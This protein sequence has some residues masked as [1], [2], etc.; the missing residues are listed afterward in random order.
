MS[1]PEKNGFRRRARGRAPDGWIPLLSH[2]VFVVGVLVAAGAGAAPPDQDLDGVLDGADNCARVAN[3]DQA[4]GDALPAGDAC[5]CSDVDVDRD[6]D[7]ADVAALERF[8]AGRATRPGFDSARCGAAGAPGCDAADVATLRR[9]LAGQLPGL[10]QACAAAGL[11]H[12]ADA[13]DD[14]VVNALDGSIVGFCQGADLVARCDCRE[15]DIDVD[16]DVDF[17][18][19]VLVSS[20]F[21]QSGFP[22]GA[23]DPGP[24]LVRFVSPLAGGFTSAAPVLARVRVSEATAAVTI[25]GVPAARLAGGLFEAS[26]ALPQGA[27]ELEA[28]A[29]GASCVFETARVSLR[30]PQLEALELAPAGARLVQAGALQPLEL[31]GRYED[32]SIRDLTADAGTRYEGSNAYIASVNGPVV[33]AVSNGEMAVTASFGG[34]S[35]RS[36]I[37]VEIGVLLEAFAVSPEEETLRGAGATRALR[38]TGRFSD[39]SSRDLTAASTGTLWSSGDPAVATVS[40]DGLVRASASGDVAISARNEA[41]SDAAAIRVV[42]SSGSGFL[43]GEAFDDTLGLPLGAVTATLVEDG[44]GRLVPAPTTLADER[45]RFLLGGAGGD[46]L[47]RVARQGYTRVDRRA[48]IPAGTAATLLDA[49]L[50]PLDPRENPIAAAV[51]GSAR[52]AS[53]R[54]SLEVPPGAL[55]LD[56]ALALTELSSQGLQGRLPLGWSPVAALDVSPDAIAFGQPASARLPSEMRLPPGSAVVAARYD[57]SAARWIALAPATVDATGGAASV[58]LPGTG[59]VALLVPDGA[60]FAPPAPVAGE[61]L[62]GVGE[63]ALPA[64]ALAESEVLPPSAP[65]GIG[66]RAVGELVLRS[67]TPFPSGTAVEGRVTEQFDLFDLSMIVPQPFAQDL[68]VFARPRLAETATAGTR[69][70]ITPS[71]D[72]SLTELAIGMVKIAVVPRAAGVGGEVL[73]ADGGGAGDAAGARLELPAGA[74]A[75]ATIALVRALGAGELD[76]PLPAGLELLAAARVDLSSAS[77]AQPGVVS[78][79][80]P[81]GLP[82][83]AQVLVARR[84]RDPDGVARL[85]LVGLARAAAGRLFSDA[86]LAGATLPGVAREG[87]YLFVRAAA[88]L[89]FVTGV[90]RDAGGAPVAQAL[91]RTSTA[92]FAALT[93]SPE[94][95]YLVAGAVGAPTS[96]SALHIPTRDATSGQATVAAVGELATLDLVLGVVAPAVVSTSPANA[97]LDVLRNAP[98]AVRFSEPIEPSSVSATSVVLATGGAPVPG[99]RVLS[100]DGLE[101]RVLPD[102]GLA[103]ATAYTLALSGGLRDLAGNALAPFAG[104]AFTTIDTSKPPQPAAGVITAELPDDQGFVSVTAT[105]GTAEPLSGITLV[106]PRTRETF[107]A[108][109]QSDGAFRLRIGA[110]I[111]DTLALTFRD[112][113]RR[114]LSLPITQ[115]ENPD[116]R[117]AFGGGGGVVRGPSGRRARVMPRAL[118]GG[119]VFQLR[120]VADPGALPALPA[121]FAYRDRFELAIEGAEFRRLASLQLSETQS[122]FAPLRATGFPFEASGSL[123]VPAN[124]L[125]NGTLDFDAVAE[126]SSGERHRVSLETLVVPSN[127]RTGVVE[128]GFL[129]SFPSLFLRAPEQSLVSQQL[130]VSAVAPPARVDFELPDPG[131]APNVVLLLVRLTDV[132]GQPRLAIVDRFERAQIEAMA[133]LRTTGRELPG[134]TLSGSYAVVESSAPLAAVSGQLTGPAATVALGGTPFVFEADAPNAGFRLPVVAGAPFA[135]A[136]VDPESGVSRGGTSGVAPAQGEQDLGEPLAASAT[137]MAVSLEPGAGALVPIDARVVLRFSEPV[138]AQSVTSGSVLLTDAAGSAVPGGFS[139]AAEGREVRFTPSRRL[140]FGT[141]YRCSV[142]RDVVG[143]SGA[144]LPAA[145]STSFDTFAPQVLVSD[146]LDSVRDVVASGNLALAAGAVALHVLDV[147]EPDAPATLASVPLEGGVSGVALVEG[148]ALTDRNGQPVV[149]TLALALSGGGAVPGRL[150]IFS[151]ANAASPALIGAVQLT[152]PSGQTTP[153]GVPAASGTP[154]AAFVAGADAFVA[155]RGLGVERVRLGQA[156][157][158]DPAL[159]GAGLEGR[160]PAAALESATGVARLGARVLTVGAAGLIVL[161]GSSLVRLGGIGTDGQPE[162]VAALEG[163]AFDKNGDGTLETSERFDVALVANGADGTLQLFDVS[164]PASPVRLSVIRLGHPALSVAVDAEQRLALVGGGADGVSL[165][166][167]DGPASIQP[168]ELDSNQL[169]DRILG[170]VA[171]EGVAAR[172]ALA[173]A[174]G[175]GYVADGARGVSVVQ[176]APPRSTFERVARD[177]LA[178]SGGDEE[179][180]EPLGSAFLSD[181]RILVD[182]FATVPPRTSAS[183][184]LE[185]TPLAGGARVL[186]VAGGSRFDLRNGANSVPVEIRK[187]V[188]STGAAAAFVVRDGGGRALARFDLSLAP[189]ETTALELESLLVAPDPLL[190]GQSGDVGRLSLGGLF[191]DGRVRNLTDAARGTTWIAEE[192]AVA[193]VDGAGVVTAV[194]GGTTRLE[195]ANGTQR[196]SAWVNVDDQPAVVALGVSERLL[197]L[198]RIGAQAQL[199]V[200]GRLSNGIVANVTTG[201]GTSFTTGDPS[202]ATVDPAGLVTATGEGEA[203]ITVAN[204]AASLLARVFVESRPAASV[205][206]I[207][208]DAFPTPVRVDREIVA[209]ARVLGSGALEALPVRFSVELNP[210]ADTTAVTDFEGRAAGL[211]TRFGSRGTFVVTASVVD[212]ATGQTRSAS[213]DLVI[214]AGSGDGEPN[215]SLA[216]AAPLDPERPV[217]G[218]IGAG[219]ASD[220]FRVAAST[221]G[222]LRVR[223]SLPPGTDLSRVMV[224]VRASD[225]S[226]IARVTPDAFESELSAS[227]GAGAAFVSL[228]SSAATLL[229]YA[230]ETS[231]AQGPVVVGG[232]VPG[233]GGPG[234]LVA[235]SGSG[236]SSRLDENVVLFGGIAGELVSATPTAL[237]VR[238]PANGVNGQIEVVVRGRSAA[239]PAFATGVATP[240]PSEYTAPDPALQRRHPSGLLVIAN[241]LLASFLPTIGRARVEALVAPLGGAVVGFLPTFNTYEI[242]FA[243]VASVSALDARRAQLLASPDVLRAFPSAIEEPSQLAGTRPGADLAAAEAAQRTSA[244]RVIQAERAVEAVRAS[245]GFRDAASLRAVTVGVIDSGFDPPADVAGEYRVGTVGTVELVDAFAPLDASGFLPVQPEFQEMLS[246]HGTAVTS[247]IAAINQGSHSSGILSGVFRDGERFFQTIVYRVGDDSINP[248]ATG[249]PILGFPITVVWRALEDVRTRN[250]SGR[251]LD[252]LNLSFGSTYASFGE[253]Y[254]SIRQEYQQR[255]QLVADRTLVSAAA[256]NLGIDARLNLPSAVSQ[257]VPGVIAVGAVAV[258]DRDQT[259]EKIDYRAIFGS[260]RSDRLPAGFPTSMLCDA[261]PNAGSNCGPAV[262]LAAPGEDVLVN[263]AGIRL[264]GQTL[265]LASGTSVAA[266]MVTAVAALLQ[267]IRP[268]PP[269]PFRPDELRDLLLRSAEDISATW[270]PSPMKRLNALAAVRLLV[271]IEELERVYIA[272]QEGPNGRLMPGRIVALDVDPISTAQGLAEEIDLSLATPAGSWLGGRPTMLALS[273]DGSELWALVESAAPALGDGLLVIRTD[274]RERLAFIPLSGATFPAA[275]AVQPAQGA[276]LRLASNRAQ[277]VFSRDGRVLYVATGPEIVIVNAV[278]RKLVRRLAD[279]PSPYRDDIRAGDEARFADALQRLRTRMRVGILVNQDPSA[280]FFVAK[281]LLELVNLALAPDGRTLYVSA[282]TGIGSGNQPGALISLDVDLYRDREPQRVGLQADLSSYFSLGSVE[283]QSDP[284]AD[285]VGVGQ[286][287][288]PE[289][290]AVSPDGKHVYLLNPGVKRF[291]GVPPDEFDAASWTALLG[292]SMLLLV[293]PG[294]GI[295]GLMVGMSAFFTI[296]SNQQTDL[297]RAYR[298]EF[299]SGVTLLAAPGFTGVFSTSP[300]LEREWLFPA[301]VI[302]G[303]NP[304]HAGQSLPQG[305]TFSLG[306]GRLVNHRSVLHEVYARRPKDMAIRPDGKRAIVGFFQTGNFG[307][308]DLETQRLFATNPPSAPAPFPFYADPDRRPASSAFHDLVAVTP[309]LRL[310]SHLWPELGLIVGTRISGPSAGLLFAIP[311]PQEALLFVHDVEYSQSGRFAVATHSGGSTV[312]PV[313]GVV[314]GFVDPQSGLNFEPGARLALSN[315]GYQ[316]LSGGVARLMGPGGAVLHE[317]TANTAATFERGGGAI[318]ILDDRV[319]SQELT[320]NA[321]R[322]VDVGD[323]VVNPIP[324]AHYSTFPLRGAT[325][326]FLDYDTTAAQ[327]NRF[328]KPR[329]VA[330]QPLIFFESPGFGDHVVATTEIQL[331]W[332]DARAR[333]ILVRVFDLDDLVPDPADP[334]SFELVPRELG[335]SRLVPSAAERVTRSTK[336]GLRSLIGAIFRAPPYLQPVVGHHYRIEAQLFTEPAGG[337][338]LATTDF[339]VVLDRKIVSQPPPARSCKAKSVSL[340]LVPSPNNDENEGTPGVLNPDTPRVL[341]PM[342]FGRRATLKYTI[343]PP[344]GRSGLDGPVTLQLADTSL[345]VQLGPNAPQPNSPTGEFRGQF[346]I[347]IQRPLPRPAD[348]RYVGSEFEVLLSYAF[349]GCLAE[350]GGLQST[351]AKIPVLSNE[352]EY[353]KKVIPPIIRSDLEGE[354]CAVSFTGLGSTADAVGAASDALGYNP[355]LCTGRLP[356]GGLQRI[357]TN[358]PALADAESVIQL[359]DGRVVELFES[360]GFLAVQRELGSGAPGTGGN[361]DTWVEKVIR[362]RPAPSGAVKDSHAIELQGSRDQPIACLGAMGAP[363]AEV[364]AVTLKDFRV[365]IVFQR[366]Q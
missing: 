102:G 317:V 244:S 227:L 360:E 211:L 256:G 113:E 74:L 303:W 65:A 235:V 357:C 243:G 237:Q 199:V 153:A 273:P 218:T 99:Q 217:A 178:A 55:A 236:F 141:G 3:L 75:Q 354:G 259:G 83:G 200:S 193:R 205:T 35:D 170:R 143:V 109:T 17:A 315:L 33:T 78:V 253:P 126:D 275:P 361:T 12:D 238:V 337:D 138:D 336:R 7:A 124:F 192:P 228:E 232:A 191:S 43:R 181:D 301:D 288:E 204:G 188:A 276:P 100:P 131:G 340:T 56:A 24:P 338:L 358:R 319:I 269:T 70:P 292:A 94:A 328:H 347:E 279:L 148:A 245:R 98:I 60:P 194:A 210:P 145:L 355:F 274:T 291:S 150:S 198:P 117:T 162:A 101:L 165:V 92:P 190:L 142:S 155:V 28:R 89:G 171:T 2:A 1:E 324:R 125:V 68:L 5:Q 261:L 350:P 264:V 289:A 32:G 80:L 233:A 272:D 157:P 173:L 166:D 251:A 280:A 335:E 203:V 185:E 38:A 308:L 304:S 167:L 271:P 248:G 21:T 29:Q 177:P 111:G 326:T 115:F 365:F 252:A 139:L 182:V 341:K 16:G 278:E 116:G 277:P 201:F 334:G 31:V 11:Q 82:P 168:I 97:A 266:P 64:A 325:T 84:F 222:T 267:S 249:D 96:A 37:T 106:N 134:A 87:D 322:T 108:R 241:R 13:N 27:T 242:E 212:P 34:L 54:V 351:R 161:E 18:D 135:L 180:L 119:A 179:A 50:T 356:F 305:A 169:D 309:S 6:V 110:E 296:N 63:I 257:F 287:D 283:T 231:F 105:V 30:I 120:D 137:T 270:T 160:Y 300:G 333:S 76:A 366:L 282:R 263:A 72:F 133:A 189:H 79:P 66:A 127:P 221:D 88:P 187:D 311:S 258:E 307:I 77:L 140:R 215:D 223:L 262:T 59:Q 183:L 349:N 103:S 58:S 290:V 159:P 19:L 224:V 184:Q 136:F 176:L 260:P 339:Q 4:N 118:V 151:L 330:I 362:D 342:L 294:A 240:A 25:N 234:T 71:R 353:F 320:A 346:E 331:G 310:D 156:I 302:R 239:G 329:G 213:A 295:I 196:A 214:E 149:G 343:A 144:R 265:K 175:V 81:A 130:E 128:E 123:L 284:T 268:D 298:E 314:P 51:G 293:N 14:G 225:G 323:P 42:V 250:R 10:P 297:L 48:E 107:S 49:R 132:A 207:A 61:P 312:G 39:G 164:V 158:V 332:R 172:M 230:L 220:S 206:G 348:R 209:S 219:D 152:T 52:S 73:G 121:G 344:D 286:G 46:A 255:L 69:F 345:L 62:A 9:W 41:Q 154:S 316:I 90:V 281:P 57:A 15:A 85:E 47:V 306:G 202:V 247:V 44:T 95:R 174:R 36:A 26:V 352:I 163:F 321:A 45:G 327:G 246:G 226:E 363:V 20:L 195:A 8:L 146:A 129:A 208:L 147:S 93:R 318:T 229:A 122:R 112:A 23:S 359:A 364:Q 197:S 299:N 22:P 114:E 67:T 104:V 254:L 313:T 285:A 40:S 86:A 91:V 186:R 216:S 53:G